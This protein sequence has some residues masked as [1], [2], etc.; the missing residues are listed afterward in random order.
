[1]FLNTHKPA[2]NMFGI[3]PRRVALL[4]LLLCLTTRTFTQIPAYTPDWTSL[5][6]RP[7]PQWWLDA[8]FGIFIHWGVYSVPGFS[9]KGNY[10]E[11]YLRHMEDSGNPAIQQAIRKF[12]QNNFGDKSYYD[13]ADDFKATLFDPEAWAEL[14]EKSGARYVV[15]TSKHHDGFCLWPSKQAAKSWGFPWTSTDRGPGRD[16]VGDLFQA[17]NKTRVVPGL[18]YSQYEWYN[19]LW[20]FDR[21]TYVREHSYPQMVDLV[22][23]Y[24][25]SIIWSDGDWDATDDLWQ[26]KEFLTWLYND[27]PVKEEVVVNDRWGAGTRF[28]HGDF[29]TPEYQPELEFDDHPWEE[30]RGMGYSYGY[31]RDEDATDYLSAKALV[32]HLIDKVSKGGNFLLDIGPDAYG[33]IPPIM[34]ERLL[35][36]GKWLD[37]NGQAIYQTQRWRTP[38][39][40][41]EGDRNYKTE[42]GA[43]IVLKQT[44]DPEAGYAVKEAFFTWNKKDN[45]LFVLIPEYP[46]NRKLLLKNMPLP[47]NTNITLL[48]T[49]EPLRWSYRT[50]HVDLDLDSREEKVEKNKP[51][52]NS[53]T[54]PKGKDIV[55]EFPEYHPATFKSTL[56]TVIKIENFGAFAPRPTI[57]TDFSTPNMLPQVQI[58]CDDPTAII[59]F[60]LDGSEPGA[61]SRQYVAPLVLKKATTVKAKA[62]VN[63][64]LESKTDS[65]R[66]R[67]YAIMPALEMLRAPRPGLRRENIAVETF[68]C[69]A[70]LEEGIVENTATGVKINLPEPTT[71]DKLAYIWKGFVRIPETGIYDFHLHSDDGSQLFLDNTLVVDN[72]GNH[73]PALKTG[74]AGLQEG[75]HALKLVYFNSGGG[76]ALKLSMGVVN[77]KQREFTLDELAH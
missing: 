77:G 61:H 30:S 35:E 24:K 69:Q 49:G 12:H 62:Y 3:N 43:D 4:T 11:W 54:H 41:G 57:L 16:L 66:V 5:D 74:M 1:L 17:L 22:N 18:Y 48:E 60:T 20:L 13:F 27:S 8:K 65:A 28:H 10:A 55:V 76:T 32:L 14:F 34:Q 39:Q 25:P 42:K 72:D 67:T 50:A 52:K 37:I 47:P 68:T 26:S 21:E 71:T 45:H 36:I 70:V 33:K 75:W 2:E 38:S 44:I 19:P 64:A 9:L 29:Y 46:K 63:G 7:T 6:S 51:A 15:L 58:S 40:W 56:A 73:P 23:R 53:A 59:R 31:N